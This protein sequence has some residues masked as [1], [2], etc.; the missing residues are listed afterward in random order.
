[1][2]ARAGR[3]YWKIFGIIIIMAVLVTL[4]FILGRGCQRKN[5]KDSKAGTVTRSQKPSGT[6]TPAHPS[7]DNGT[8]TENT[9]SE[10]PT[11]VASYDEKLPCI[12]G[13]Q[14]VYHVTE[15]SDGTWEVS[16]MTSQPCDDIVAVPEQ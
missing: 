5:D 12:G 14:S 3:N 1:M 4:A 7:E 16:P 15:Y 13:F 10:P 6:P 9:D 2:A 11:I 8:V